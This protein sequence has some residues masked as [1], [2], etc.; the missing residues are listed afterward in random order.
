ME[1]IIVKR[2]EY[3]NLHNFE[4]FENIAQNESFVHKKVEKI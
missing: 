4:E 2:V 1:K 3:I